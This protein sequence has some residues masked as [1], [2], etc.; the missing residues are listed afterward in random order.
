MPNWQFFLPQAFGIFQALSDGGLSGEIICSTTHMAPLSLRWKDCHVDF[1][2]VTGCT[3][4][5]HHDHLKYSQW[6]QI[7]Q[8]DCLPFQWSIY[9]DFSA[10]SMYIGHGWVITSHS[11]LWY[12]ITY[13][14]HCYLAPA[15]DT[16][17]KSLILDRYVSQ[18]EFTSGLLRWK[19]KWTEVYFHTTWVEIVFVLSLKCHWRLVFFVAM[20][21]EWTPCCLDEMVVI[22][23]FQLKLF[24]QQWL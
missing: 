10:R 11:F 12:V 16:E 23:K 24:S 1:F 18:G 19:K 14:C 20:L 8:H 9:E 5:G 22:S 17:I 15:S 2:V 6:L 7:S 3:W 4:G 13:P 21:C